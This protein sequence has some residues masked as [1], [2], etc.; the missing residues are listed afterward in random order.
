MVI[1][2]DDGMDDDATDVKSCR[3]HD[4]DATEDLISL[5]SDSTDGAVARRGQA[6]RR[7]KAPSG[8]TQRVRSQGTSSAAT[9]AVTAHT[10]PAAAASASRRR[11]APAAHKASSSAPSVEG[12][13]HVV[14][15]TPADASQAVPVT[16]SLFSPLSDASSPAPPSSSIDLLGPSP[17]SS[18][19]NSVMAADPELDQMGPYAPASVGR[20]RPIDLPPHLFDPRRAITWKNIPSRYRIIW[21]DDEGAHHGWVI[22][23]DL[24]AWTFTRMRYKEKYWSTSPTT[25]WRPMIWTRPTQRP[26]AIA[27][28]PSG[29]P[30]ET[31][32]RADAVMIQTDEANRAGGTCPPSFLSTHPLPPWRKEPSLEFIADTVNYCV[33]QVSKGNGSA[34][35]PGGAKWYPLP[36]GFAIPPAGTPLNIYF[37]DSKIRP[38]NAGPA[39]STASSAKVR[40]SAAKHTHPPTA[41]QMSS[42][43]ASGSQLSSQGRPYSSSTRGKISQ[44]SRIWLRPLTATFSAIR[45]QQPPRLPDAHRACARGV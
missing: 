6:H 14:P 40:F 13:P 3:G 1:D 11:L 37:W 30:L 17:L 43:V 12:R 21:V 28:L 27:P 44:V 16:T 24:S 8:A 20:R 4:G 19:P 36:R 32:D 39:I 26:T 15:P 29:T 5:Y 9:T 7:S 22:V 18:T 38:H 33:A 23:Y 31:L 2:I 42:A 45:L 41:V 25:L 34:L 10:P 35:R